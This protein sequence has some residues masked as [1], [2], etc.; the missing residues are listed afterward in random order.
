MHSMQTVH[1]SVN[2]NSDQVE[3]KQRENGQPCHMLGCVTYYEICN[4]KYAV[5]AQLKYFNYPI[6]DI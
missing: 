2:D 1:F 3:R 6:F 5:S 4:T